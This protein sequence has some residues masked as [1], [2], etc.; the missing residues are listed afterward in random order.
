MAAAAAAAVAHQAGDDE[1]A[2]KE[3]AQVY[4]LIKTHQPLLLLHH[5]SQQQQQQLAYSLLTEAMR[6]LNVALS[7]MKH[8][9][10]SPAPA[11]I[12]VNMIKPE[13]T[14]A[15]SST[16]TAAD[17]GDN[18]VGGGKPT[19]RS[20]AK[21]RRINGEDKS[22]C[23][24]LTTMVPHEDG[25]QWRK[26]GE[27][28]IQGTDFTRSYFRCTYKDDKGCQATKQIQQKD[29]NYPPNFQVTYSN[30]Y[31]CNSCT[32]DRIINSSNHPAL[33]NLAANPIGRP[34]DDDDT[35]CNKMI[36]QEPQVAWLPP[37]LTAISNSLDETPALH[38]YQA[39]EVPPSSK[40]YCS[41]SVAGTCSSNSSVISCYTDEFVHQMGQQ[42]ETTV[43]E[44]ALGLGADLDDPYFYDS[45]LLLLYENL[46]NCY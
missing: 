37:P 46:M 13:V 40:I 45:N 6:A 20:A 19:R 41:D 16:A 44:E 43:T 4:E 18:Q 31:T 12:P 36:K 30:D 42:L 39:D 29:N 21:R 5:N 25:Y 10:S 1:V 2:M 23:F 34:D 38:V 8:L 9:P 27:K 15:S 28:K 26:Y 7:V 3:V 11:A 17:G 35:I 24:Q 32:T 33:Q 14:P 22:S